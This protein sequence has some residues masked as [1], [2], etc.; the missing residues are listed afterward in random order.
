MSSNE[1]TDDLAFF[2]GP[3]EYL[4]AAREHLTAFESLCDS[5]V[6]SCDYE[7]V[8]TR[9][10]KTSEEV[11]SLRF[12]KRP[13]PRLRAKATSILSDIR[14]ALDQAVCD[15]AV[16]LGRKN[17]KNV[18]F[19]LGQ[20]AADLE[21]AIKGRCRNVHPEILDFIRACKPYYGGNDIVRTACQIIT[22]KHSRI[23]RLSLGGKYTHLVSNEN[24]FIRSPCKFWI[25][26]WN[27]LKNEL[28]YARVG[29]GGHFQMDINHPIKV[30]LGEGHAPFDGP[31]SAALR[32]IISETERI[33]LGLEAETARILRSQSG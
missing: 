23:L 26:K 6:R 27:R 11:I 16:A 4:A 21:D 5:F 7:V 22:D 9:D 25:N 29:P 32:D 30:V 13:T 31:A 19:P 15:A 24:L 8:R 1:V 14:N 33:I 10:N 28:E 20:N 17:A 12:S 2:E 3:L 18:Y